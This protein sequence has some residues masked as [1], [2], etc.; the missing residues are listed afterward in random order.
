[1]QCHIQLVWVFKRIFVFACIFLL[2]YGCS[3]R[4][5]LINTY[6]QEKQS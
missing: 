3:Y 2:Y 1:M 6:R 4:M 5:V